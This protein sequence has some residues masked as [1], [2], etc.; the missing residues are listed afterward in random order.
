MA[1]GGTRLK[2]NAFEMFSG[3][4]NDSR[5]ADAEEAS[6]SGLPIGTLRW[7]A[8][9]PSEA[10]TFNDACFNR[11]I[12]LHKYYYVKK[13]LP[14][15]DDPGDS[16]PPP[17]GDL[18]KMNGVVGWVSSTSSANYTQ[19]A[20]KPF[21]TGL[22]AHMRWDDLTT[23]GTTFDWTT[24]DRVRDVCE[25]QDKFW[26][27]MLIAG[28]RAKGLPAYAYAGLPADE[29]IN[30]DGGDFIAF[31]SDTGFTRWMNVMR[32]ISDRYKSSPKLAQWRVTGF[33]SNHGE[34]WFMGGSAGLA[35]WQAQWNAYCTRKGTPSLANFDGLVAAYQAYEK[36]LWTTMASI[37]PS[38]V[39]LSQAAGDAF[40]DVVATKPHTDPNRH[41]QRLATWSE[42]RTTV[43][44]RFVGQFN[45]AGPGDGASGYITW[46]SSAFG[47]SSAKPSRIW[48]QPVG[49]VTSGNVRLTA[50]EFV[51]MLNTLTTKGYSAFELYQSD[52]LAATDSSP[53][54]DGLTMKNA[55]I[56]HINDW[57]P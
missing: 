1:L 13:G 48:A 55:I 45:G 30:A 34:P 28:N 24:Y 33:W 6:R 46:L 35:K 50:S 10:G 38:Y 27:G 17:S 9:T 57:K 32:A 47:P 51:A 11:S 41:P 19:I 15:P 14:I 42:I 36:K 56:S 5:I 25:A 23:N 3:T 4:E 31:W 29:L 40:K 16:D 22:S 44:N 12:G 20:S 39:T 8:I 37:F 21:I 43:G 53:T 52:A 49:G 26:A 7:N 54:G 18:R 2:V